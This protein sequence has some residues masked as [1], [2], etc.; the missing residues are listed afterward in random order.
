MSFRAFRTSGGEE[1]SGAAKKILR[2]GVGDAQDDM[3]Q[4]LIVRQAQ[5]NEWRGGLWKFDDVER[6]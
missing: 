6:C 4:T 3:L 5:E 1:S 2:T